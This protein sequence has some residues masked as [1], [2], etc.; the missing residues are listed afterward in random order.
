M[1]INIMDFIKPVM[2]VDE[3][4][5]KGGDEGWIP[6]DAN[7]LAFMKP[8]WTSAD[9]GGWAVL[10]R[11]KAGYNAPKHKHLGSIHAYIVSG[12][13]QLRNSVLEAGDYTYEP[14]G[15]IHEETLAL[16]DTVHLNIGDGP[17][18]FFN[19][20]GITHYFSWEQVERLRVAHQ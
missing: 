19:E 17:V 8:L 6:I 9:S 16:E 13:L 2:E 3:V 12:K 14:N 18:V 5:I 1:K 7:G 15:V 11:W 10:Y 4:H 20:Q